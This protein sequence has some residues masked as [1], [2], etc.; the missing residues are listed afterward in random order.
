MVLLVATFFSDN[1]FVIM[2]SMSSTAL[3]I[4]AGFFIAV[5]YVLSLR[6]P[7]SDDEDVVGL[8]RGLVAKVCGYSV[9]GYFTFAVS[10]AGLQQYM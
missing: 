10:M 7:I 2:E 6:L 5:M 8:P 1:L 9:A 4:E 3:N